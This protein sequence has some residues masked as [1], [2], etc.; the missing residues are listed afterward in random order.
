[1]TSW[2]SLT[3]VL[4]VGGA[5]PFSGSLLTCSIPGPDDDRYVVDSRRRR[6]FDIGVRATAMRQMIEALV[7][8]QIQLELECTRIGSL[9][10]LAGLGQGWQD[11]LQASIRN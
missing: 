5:R 9:A 3:K 4:S 6:E 11:K 7:V 8:G 10:A 2:P 1:M